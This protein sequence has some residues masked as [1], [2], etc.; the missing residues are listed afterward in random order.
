MKKLKRIKLISLAL[1]TTLSAFAL[2]GCGED[3]EKIATPTQT[4]TKAVLDLDLKIVED[5]NDGKVKFEIITNLPEGTEGTLTLSDV[6]ST[7]EEETK[8]VIVNGSYITQE[9]SVDGKP[10]V[11]GLYKAI[12]QTPI[13]NEQPD[14]VKEIVGEDYKNINTS[15]IVDGESGNVIIYEK[16]INIKAE[17]VT[18]KDSLDIHELDKQTLKELYN[19]LNKEYAEQK[20][21]PNMPKWAEFGRDFNARVSEVGEK[22]KDTQLKVALGDIKQLHLEYTKILQGNPGDPEHF[23]KQIEAILGID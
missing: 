20:E 14:S 17:D 11:S 10:L 1:A 18:D 13:Y 12:F 8:V 16:E 2:I 5:V 15:H 23:K 6:G 22:I 3:T 9:F 4:D 7:Y 21:N 19:N